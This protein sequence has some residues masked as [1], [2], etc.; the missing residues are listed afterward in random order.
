M[1]KVLIVEDS[2]QIR[3]AV[4][5]FFADKSEGAITVDAAAD[6]DEGMKAVIENTYD[7]VILDIML[8]GPSGFMI[9]KKLRAKSDCPIVFLTAL[10]TEDNILQGYET[11]ADEYMVKPFSLKVLYTKCLG[12]HQALSIKDAGVYKRR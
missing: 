11:G 6:G 4:A 1:A 2:F 8:P 7:L 3:E 5:D 9:C 12:R 10:G